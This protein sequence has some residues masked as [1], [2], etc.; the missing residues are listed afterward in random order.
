MAQVPARRPDQIADGWL[1]QVQKKGRRRTPGSK[2]SR[3]GEWWVA[4]YASRRPGDRDCDAARPAGR[5]RCQPASRPSASTFASPP[6]PV[7]PGLAGLS[8]PVP[9]WDRGTAIAEE[10]DNDPESRRPQR[11]SRTADART[12]ALTGKHLGGRVP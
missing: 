11:A 1:V 4:V 6:S 8:V 7:L 5:G 12:P 2:C 3:S 9:G 10:A